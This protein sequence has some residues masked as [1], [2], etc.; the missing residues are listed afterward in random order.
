MTAMISRRCVQRRCSI[1]TVSDRSG[2]SL[3]SVRCIEREAPVD[4]RDDRGDLGPAHWPT[5]DRG[6]LY[7]HVAA[8][9]REERTL[10]GVEVLRD[11]AKTNVVART[12]GL[13]D[14]S[15]VFGHVALAYR[16]RQSCTGR[17]PAIRKAPSRIACLGQGQLHQVPTVSRLRLQAQLAQWLV[18]VNFERP[19]YATNVI[20][21]VRLT[22]EHCRCDPCQ[23]R[24][25]T[26]RSRS[27]GCHRP[28]SS[29]LRG[30]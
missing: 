27:R 11:N 10:P 14:W 13:I 22:E 24:R 4:E 8:W 2:A 16:S 19:S 20:P 9:L 7:Q 28:G 18:T 17:G 29:E 30:P 1:R 15:A 6:R 25:P 3:R 26:T 5:V 23:S 12:A 21:A